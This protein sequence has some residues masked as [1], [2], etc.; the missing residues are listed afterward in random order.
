[1]REREREREEG[2][3]DDNRENEIRF[4]FRFVDDVE[5]W[6]LSF[7]WCTPQKASR[8][9]AVRAELFRVVLDGGSSSHFQMKGP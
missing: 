5:P 7:S 2:D 6:S 3:D 9:K 1:M 8:C 4:E